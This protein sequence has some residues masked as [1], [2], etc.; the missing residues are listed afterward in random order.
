MTTDTL[1]A[2]SGGIVATRYCHQ[3]HAEADALFGDLRAP[4]VQKI[5]PQ[6]PVE[7]YD[8]RG[9]HLTRMIENVNI[10]GL[11]YIKR[12]RTRVSGSKA[13]KHDGWVT[14]S[15]SV[16]EGLNIFD[17][18]TAD[19]VVAQVSTD[20][21]LERVEEKGERID[22]P[23]HVPRVT[24]L[25]TK[26]EG[27]KI[28][29]IPVEVTLNFQVCGDKPSGDQPYLSDDKFLSETQN[30]IQ[31]IVK[32]G[33]L[34]GQAKKQYDDRL[35]QID[36][37]ARIDRLAQ[38]D[39]LVDQKI[40]SEITCSLVDSIDI[41][42]V[43]KQ[44]PGVRTVGHVIVIPDFGAVSLGEIEVG[45]EEPKAYSRSGRPVC[46]NGSPRLSNYFELNMFNMELGCI[47]NASLQ[48]GKARTNGQ[49]YP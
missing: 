35:A 26:F 12:A 44:I 22:R 15:A 47:G 1:T 41:S 28:C 13:I 32:S 46:G 11:I 36:R 9:G 10:E 34:F 29:G 42:E 20:H 19:R 7:L 6:I 30:R 14:L 4:I 48:A 33:F 2:T 37:L 38:I 45:V 5:E 16:L 40:G 17:V 27:L 3:F 49:S 24:F 18:I 39:T 21:P 25:G 31:K 43:R 8:E 23:S